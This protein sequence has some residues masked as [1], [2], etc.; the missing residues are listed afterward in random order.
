MPEKNK[1]VPEDTAYEKIIYISLKNKLLLPHQLQIYFN[2][3]TNFIKL[4]NLLPL[5]SY[6]HSICP[7]KNVN[8][9]FSNLFIDRI[10]KFKPSS[11][12]LFFSFSSKNYLITKTFN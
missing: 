8:K 7:K 12:K 6:V 5:R 4:R 9:N 10:G 11:L 3:K 2:V 1:E